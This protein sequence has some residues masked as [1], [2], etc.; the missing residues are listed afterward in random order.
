MP[1]YALPSIGWPA[2][3]SSSEAAGTP[4]EGAAEEGGETV[5][6]AG[7]AEGPGGTGVV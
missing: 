7:G 6:D 5:V 3:Q 1:D 4:P 2:G